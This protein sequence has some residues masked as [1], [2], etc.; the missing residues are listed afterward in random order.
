MSVSLFLDTLKTGIQ[1]TGLF[2][3]I[4][5]SF[6]ITFGMISKATS[7]SS[8]EFKRLKEKRRLDRARSSENPIAFNTCEAWTDPLVQ[9]DPLEQQM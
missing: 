6:S 3:D 4:L 8:A 1:F 7:T 9:A 2:G 5:R